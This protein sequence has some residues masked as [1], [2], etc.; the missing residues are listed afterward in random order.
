MYQIK[1]FTLKSRRKKNEEK[2]AESQ[3]LV[4]PYQTYYYT[5]GVDGQERKRDGED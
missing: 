1:L 2:G 4:G 5:M 3:I